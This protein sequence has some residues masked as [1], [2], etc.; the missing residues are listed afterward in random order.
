[1]EN[2]VLHT[3]VYTDY[4]DTIGQDFLKLIRKLCPILQRE[5]PI[6]VQWLNREFCSDLI[7]CHIFV[8]G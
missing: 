4:I 7:W 8:Q 5:T 1:M 2:L 6:I 3:T